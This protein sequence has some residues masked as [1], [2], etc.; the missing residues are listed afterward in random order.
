MNLESFQTEGLLRIE[1][2]PHLSRAENICRYINVL[3]LKP[4]SFLGAMIESSDPLIVKRR[5]YWGTSTG[6]NSTK[7]LIS[8]LKTLVLEIND[9]SQR[10]NQFVLEEASTYVQEI[11]LE[12]MLLTIASS[13][14]RILSM[15]KTY[16]K[17]MR[18]TGLSTPLKL[19]RPSFS[20]KR[21][22]WR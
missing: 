14:L 1:T 18:R 4:K 3:H 19:S 13:R 16:P 20:T 5:Q 8:G 7:G 6:W 15:R 11:I 9:G 10:W 17:A 12:M 2:D 21:P 22:I